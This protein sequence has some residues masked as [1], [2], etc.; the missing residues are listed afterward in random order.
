MKQVDKNRVFG[1]LGKI[2][3]GG[4]VKGWIDNKVTDELEMIIDEHSYRSV[5]FP[6]RALV[7]EKCEPNKEWLW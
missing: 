7:L 4:K 6:T 2:P 3:I 1:F 5:L